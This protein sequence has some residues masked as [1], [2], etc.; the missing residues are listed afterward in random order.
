[1]PIVNMHLQRIRSFSLYIREVRCNRRIKACLRSSLA[2]SVINRIC[3]LMQH[4]A[5]VHTSSAGTLRHAAHA[6]NTQSLFAPQ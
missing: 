4:E 6:V 2:Q 1:M 3:D 5:N